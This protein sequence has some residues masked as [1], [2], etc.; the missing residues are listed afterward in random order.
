MDKNDF[1]HALE[2]VKKDSPKR[3]FK[4]SYDLL[5]NLKDIDLKKTEN[6]ID[7]FAQLHF[8]RGR[9]V[10]ICGLVAGELKDQSAQVFA[11]TLDSDSFTKY[12]NDK[13]LTKKLANEHDF[14]VA[15]AS[16]MPKVAAAFGKVLGPRGKMPN[17]KAGCVVPPNANLKPLAEKLAKTVRISVKTSMVYMCRIGNEDM[18]DAEI[19]DNA[20]TIYTAL[21]NA[22]PHQDQNIKSVMLKKTMSHPVK[23]GAVTKAAQAAKRTG[24]KPAKAA[25]KKEEAEPAE[26]QE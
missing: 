9:D 15:Q 24:K 26:K 1:I 4:Q 12:Q 17:P 13:K 23:V 25:A 21:S 20:V 3:N 11:T 8:G 5:I 18:P 16:I 7:I 14:F 22:L 2:A 10:K 6:Q 19:I